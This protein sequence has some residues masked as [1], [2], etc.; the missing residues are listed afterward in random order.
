MRLAETLKQA[1]LRAV[2][3]FEQT[4]GKTLDR[5]LLV[6][7]GIAVCPEA[8]WRE[9]DLITYGTVNDSGRTFYIVSQPRSP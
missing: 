6:H 4:H 8:L 9:A 1:A 2:R 7:P 5:Q 3:E